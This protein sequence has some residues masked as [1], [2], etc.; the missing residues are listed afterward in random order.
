MRLAAARYAAQQDD[1]PRQ[2]Q[3]VLLAL[4]WNGEYNTTQPGNYTPAI[5]LPDFVTSN[6]T[7]LVEPKVTGANE[8]SQGLGD[9]FG[10]RGPPSSAAGLVAYTP[11]AVTMVM[12]AVA[13]ALL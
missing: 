12:A 2:V 5:G 7:K 9:I 10:E 4:L 8:S 6:G 11:Y 3:A 1:L 13:T